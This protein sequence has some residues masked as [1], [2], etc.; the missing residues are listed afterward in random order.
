MPDVVTGGS[1]SYKGKG[2]NTKGCLGEKQLR[3][4]L[5]FVQP[6]NFLFF[7]FLLQISYKQP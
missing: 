4:L 3:F 6:A 7:V 2:E 1:G 5:D